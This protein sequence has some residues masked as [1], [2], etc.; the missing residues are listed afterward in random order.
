M[1]VEIEVQ[2]E[3][4][5]L[6]WAKWKSIMFHIVRDINDATVYSEAQAKKLKK[7]FVHKN[8]RVIRRKKA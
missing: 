3:K 2:G 1:I 8:A 5:Y 6:K 7:Y 4:V